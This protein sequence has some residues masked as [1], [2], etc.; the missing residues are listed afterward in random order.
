MKTLRRLFFW[1]FPRTSW[2]WDIIV[3]LILAFIF[4]TPRDLFRD[5]PRAAS[6]QMLPSQQ[7]FLIEPKLLENV[8]EADRPQKAAEL[9]NQRYKNHTIITHVAPV[10]DEAEGEITGY[11][12]YTKP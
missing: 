10:R 2:Q 6:I 12:A 7:G 1:D 9:V 4:L 5:Q 3:T 11:I 8:P